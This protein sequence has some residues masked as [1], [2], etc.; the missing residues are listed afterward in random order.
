MKY[1]SKCQLEKEVSFFSKRIKYSD[2]LSK[3]CK[4]CSAKAD[5]ALYE[6]KKEERK[7]QALEYYYDNI[8][9]KRQYYQ[10]N[11]DKISTYNKEYKQREK[12]AISEYNKNYRSNHKKEANLRKANRKLVDPMFKLTENLR[13]RTSKLITKNN[14]NKSQRFVSYL[15]CTIPEFKKHIEAKFKENMSWFNY[16]EWHVDHIIPLDTAHTEE[17]IFRLNHYTNLQ[18]LWAFDNIKKSNK[19]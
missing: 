16:G 5:K 2:G 6:S 9:D 11:K 17:D 12:E 10:E 14:F 15:G 1:C 18:P 4:E 7:K 8:N 3:W 19:L 13:S